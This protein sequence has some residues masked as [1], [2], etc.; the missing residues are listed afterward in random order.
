M[1]DIIGNDPLLL[2][3]MVASGSYADTS[4]EVNSGIVGLSGSIGGIIGGAVKEELSRRGMSPGFFHPGVSV[5]SISA[6]SGNSIGWFGGCTHRITSVYKEVAR[7]IPQ[8]F[9]DRLCGSDLFGTEYLKGYLS[10]VA[11]RRKFHQS[12]GRGYVAVTEPVSA[13]G[14]VL[15]LG[16][17]QHPVE[18]AMASM[19][20]PYGWNGVAPVGAD[21]FV[22]GACGF[23]LLSV[24]Q[25]LNLQQLVIIG[26][27]PVP[28]QIPIGEK[29]YPEFFL[30]TLM[31]GY[32]Q[33][34]RDAAMGVDISLERELKALDNCGIA[35]C[36]I[37]PKPENAIPWDESNT[38]VLHTKAERHRAYIAAYLDG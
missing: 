26:C 2:R 37:F 36:G 8:S 22:D 4:S 34:L 16:Q 27:R 6:S 5:I 20:L 14:H 18:L 32:S 9:A 7:R 38:E 13:K 19:H 28:P 23:S 10:K 17:T 3:R 30:R 15:N 25:Q 24:I 33:A 1:L 12:K 21:S 11:K 29:W 35:W 31:L